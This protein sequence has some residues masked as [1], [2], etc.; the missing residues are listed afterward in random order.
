[1]VKTFMWQA[2]NNILPTKELLY[3]RKIVQ[4]P[5]CLICGL[6]T[7][8]VGHILWSCPSARDTWTESSPQ[9]SKCTSSEVDF[10]DI[11]AQLMERLDAEQLQLMAV[12]A[13]QIWLRRN[14]VVF[15]G[16][17]THPRILIHWAKDQ[18]DNWCK[19]NNR[20][21]KREVSQAQV[22][23]VVWTKPPLG[24]V[25]VNWDASIDKR[26]NKMGVGVLVRDHEGK[27]IAMFCSSKEYVQD[28]SMAEAIAV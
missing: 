26:Q 12:I 23:P 2:C 9:L 28:P 14:S 10:L 19:F 4:D 20:R 18:V 13:R 7:E 1:M 3:K 16:D 6:T 15:G 24:Y 5:L 17:L 11:M 8:I 27:A 21:P 22:S 25:K